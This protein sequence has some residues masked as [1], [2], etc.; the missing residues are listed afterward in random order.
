M[1]KQDT[2]NSS[3]RIR[4]YGENKHCYPI[5]LLSHRLK[6]WLLIKLRS[7]KPNIGNHHKHNAITDLINEFLMKQKA[8][9]L[10]PVLCCS[11]HKRLHCPDLQA[12]VEKMFCW[13]EWHKTVFI[14]RPCPPPS[15]GSRGSD[16]WGAWSGPL[17]GAPWLPKPT[18]LS[19]SLDGF[20]LSAPRVT[21]SLFE[22]VIFS[23][24]LMWL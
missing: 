19:S 6:N 22:L 23:H 3:K 14:I 4:R 9:Q 2:E 24:V 15:I 10:F 8:H 7:R 5:V 13:R 16:T 17:R 21:I 18:A 1:K 12:L 11:H 20:S